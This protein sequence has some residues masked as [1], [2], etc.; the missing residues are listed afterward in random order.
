MARIDYYAIEESIATQLRD[1]A[2][3][4]GVTVDVEKEPEFT[5]DKMVIVYCISREAPDDL[6]SLSAGLRTRFY[7]TFVAVCIAAA[8]DLKDA[9]E[10]R[11]DL[12]GKVEVALMQDRTFDNAQVKTSWI[13]GGD[14]DNARDGD[15]GL[16]NAAAEIEI[17]VDA[18]AIG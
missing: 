6:Q 9:M 4:S 18:T 1:D 10:A 16:F 2:T 15:E 13:G 11:D 7:V 14:F 5:E 12:L 3:L 8:L 17:V